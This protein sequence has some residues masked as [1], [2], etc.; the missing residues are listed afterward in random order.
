MIDCPTVG[1]LKACLRIQL[2]QVATL[3]MQARRVGFKQV[4]LSE[5]RSKKWLVVFTNRKTFV[6]FG[7]S[8]PPMHPP[9]RASRAS[10]GSGSSPRQNLARGSQQVREAGLL[11]GPSCECDARPVGAA[12]ERS[13]AGGYLGSQRALSLFFRW[14]KR[15]KRACCLVAKVIGH[16]FW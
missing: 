12:G 1:V 16:P 8:S 5:V 7:V 10:E 13:L 6:A 11:V 15:A 3:T 9:R 14:M 4:N 2:G